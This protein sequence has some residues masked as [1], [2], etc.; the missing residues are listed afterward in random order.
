MNYEDILFGLQPIINAD[1]I[2]DV[3]VDN[4]YL[5]SYI[6]ILDQLAVSLR[7]PQ[8]RE[9][10]RET[11]LLTQ[12]LRVLEDTLD[13]A[14]H[15]PENINNIKYWKLASELIRCV[16]NCLVDNDKNRQFLLKIA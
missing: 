14:I 9:I 10:V 7:S 8:N 6:T 13:V 4:V 11:G 15:E 3:P 12:I 1:S 5:Q 2:K 16:A